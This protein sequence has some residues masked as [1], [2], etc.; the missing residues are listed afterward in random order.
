MVFS[1]ML[2][3]GMH[4]IEFKNCIFFS[5]SEGGSPSE[6]SETELPLRHPF[7]NFLKIYKSSDKGIKKQEKWEDLQT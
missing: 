3:K 1:K 2:A 6:A 7:F 5:T 4:L